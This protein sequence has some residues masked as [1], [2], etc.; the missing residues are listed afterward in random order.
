MEYLALK[1]G[2]GM[3]IAA[4]W[5]ATAAS[6][7]VRDFDVSTE[8]IFRLRGD[9]ASIGILHFSGD[10]LDLSPQGR[11]TWP[12]VTFNQGESPVLKL[13]LAGR[14]IKYLLHTRRG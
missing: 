10:K 4:G 12:F 1:V 5:E 6:L 14:S 2:E 11:P 9:L 8:D 13:G 3:S 7:D